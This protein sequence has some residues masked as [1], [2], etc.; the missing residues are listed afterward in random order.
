MCACI[1]LDSWHTNTQH[2]R[3]HLSR[4]PSLEQSER[5]G[6]PFID[7]LSQIWILAGQKAGGEELMG[8]SGSHRGAIPEYFWPF[9]QNRGSYNSGSQRCGRL[10]NTNFRQMEEWIIQVLH[11]DAKIRVSIYFGQTDSLTVTRSLGRSI[12]WSC[13]SWRGTCP[14]FCIYKNFDVTMNTKMGFKEAFQKM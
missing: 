8:T 6:R 9:L 5:R 2:S 12:Y 7:I 4:S 10:Y 1:G 3:G 14:Q 13:P 11:S